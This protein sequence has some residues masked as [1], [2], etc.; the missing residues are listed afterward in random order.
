MSITPEPTV[1][2]N[3]SP[4]LYLHQIGN[5]D[6]LQKLYI[7]VKVPTSV[8]QELEVGRQQGIDV[9][10]LNLISWIE[11]CQVEILDFPSIDLGLGETAVIALGLTIPDSLL[12]L[13]DRLGRRYA[14]LC[15]LRYTG[16]IGVVVKAKQKGYIESVASAIT[17]LQSKGMWVSNSIIREAL[18]LSGELLD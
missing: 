15:G 7:R 8:R 2:I 10:D 5:L 18:R 16:T 11:I 14:D 17:V 1:I 4:L 12:I 9:P 6:L 13:D 3:T